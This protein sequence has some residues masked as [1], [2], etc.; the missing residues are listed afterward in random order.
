M[1]NCILKVVR[2]MYWVFLLDLVNN[3][4]AAMQSENFSLI[5]MEEALLG[6]LDGANGINHVHY[7][8][9]IYIKLMQLAR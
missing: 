5:E 7:K 9:Y 2:F 3:R 6:S 4:C 8:L 1:C